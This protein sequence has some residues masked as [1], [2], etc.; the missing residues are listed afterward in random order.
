VVSNAVV[1]TPLK[2]DYTEKGFR[3]SIDETKLTSN[4]ERPEATPSIFT[5]LKP[6]R[7][8]TYLHTNLHYRILCSRLD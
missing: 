2:G 5:T 1:S 8:D 4:L 3:L 7:N 6:T